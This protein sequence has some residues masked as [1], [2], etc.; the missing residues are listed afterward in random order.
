MLTMKLNE[1]NEDPPGPRTKT[2]DGVREGDKLED[3]VQEAISA[4]KPVE[5]GVMAQSAKFDRS[6][7]D[8]RDEDASDHLEQ[9]DQVVVRDR[10]HKGSCEKIEQRHRFL[11]VVIDPSMTSPALASMGLS[12]VKGGFRLYFHRF[13]IVI[14]YIDHAPNQCR[15]GKSI[16]L[17]KS[18]NEVRS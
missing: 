3:V 4:I 15:R 14:A 5:A 12:F 1:A 7:P 8:E 6:R 17:E 11:L 16:E 13:T 18:N 9:P 10:Y 2:L